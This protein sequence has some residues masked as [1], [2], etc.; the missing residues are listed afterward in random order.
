MSM[1]AKQWKITFTILMAGSILAALKLI[2]LII[3]WMRN[4]N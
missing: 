2:F 4:T 3:P 1:T